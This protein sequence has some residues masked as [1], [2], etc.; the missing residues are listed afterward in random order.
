MSPRRPFLL[1]P[2]PTASIVIIPGLGVLFV[3]HRLLFRSLITGR[4]RIGS[5]LNCGTSSVTFKKSA[6]HYI[7]I[8]LILVAISDLSN[9]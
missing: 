5:L 2:R 6:H 4:K 3:L 7:T 9:K 8:H 1:V